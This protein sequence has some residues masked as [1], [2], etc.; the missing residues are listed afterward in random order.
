MRHLRCCWLRVW[1]VCPHGLHPV[2]SCS[3]CRWL[4]LCMAAYLCISQPIIA[5]DAPNPLTVCSRPGYFKGDFSAAWTDSQ[6]DNCQPCP[7]S[8]Q[9]QRPAEC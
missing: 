3:R 1:P 5:P 9:C 8:L 7:V 4:D 6:K 2:V